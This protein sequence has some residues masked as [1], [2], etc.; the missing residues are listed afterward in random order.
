MRN[1]SR[2]VITLICLAGGTAAL[3]QAPAN[4]QQLEF[5]EKRIRPLLAQNCY[6]CHSH[7]GEKLKA[8][9]FLDSR[10]GV[11]KGGD[12]GPAIVPGNPRRSLVIT[13]VKWTD[14]DLQMPPKTKLG[15]DAIADL[16]EWVKMGAP[17]P[18]EAA[19]KAGAESKY[20]DPAKQYER[21]RQ[22]HW[23]WQRISDPQAPVVKNDKWPRDD[24]DRF[25]L[26]PLE[27]KNLTPSA[28]AD[29]L[30]LLRRATFDLTGLPPTPEEID[31]FLRDS[32]PGAFEKVVDRLLAS[33]RFGERW[34][35]HWLDVARYAE[36]S[37]MTRNLIYFYAWRYR[38]YV[39]DSF[40]ADKPY[41]RFITEQIAGDLLPAKSQ[42]EKDQL[43]VATGFLAIGPRDYNER[44]PRQFQMNC[45]DEQIDTMG[46]SILATTIACARCHDHKFDPIP[47]AEYYALAG[48]LTSS[49]EYTGV[50]RRNNPGN[51]F[52]RYDD[53][54]LVK[55]AG[56]KPESNAKEQ[57]D[58][59]ELREKGR[60]FMARMAMS[61]RSGQGFTQP[62]TP[63]RP[64]AMGV[65][66]GPRVGD[67]RL[68]VRGEVGEPAAIVKRGFLSIP[69]IKSAPA[70]ISLGTSGRVELAR[71]LTARDNPL[72][73]RVMANRVWRHLFGAGLVRSVD[74]FG[75]TGERPSN[76]ELLDHLATQFMNDGWSVKK[77]IRRIMLTSAY[78]QSAAFD[79]AKYK[80]DPENRLLW[81]MNQRRLE[82]E[83]IRDA[84]LASSG[85]LAT[86]RPFGSVVLDFPPMEVRPGNGRIDVSEILANTTARS[87]YLPIFRNVIPEVLD[88][89]D[90]ADP[91][92]VTGQRDVTTVAPQAL[93]MLNNTFVTAQAKE[94]ATRVAKTAA[95]NDSAR[96]D[97]AYKLAL[98]RSPTTGERSR[99]IAYIDNYLRD[100]NA[101]KSRDPD[102]NQ[103]E[104]WT[105][106]CQ[107]LF[108]SAEF[109]YLN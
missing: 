87:V 60:R 72:T 99:A 29:K 13:A 46:R 49:R 9:L 33:P 27:E 12:T 41:D 77:L 82:A 79:R 42:K 93:F 23:S 15:D 28:P 75:T 80:I 63:P 24:I 108:A 47:T 58:E 85:R 8:N 51:P 43:V 36:S 3:A 70:T 69:A 20:A 25:V 34:G 98:G 73:A 78:Q 64:L 83:S 2:V 32:S 84:M 92:V 67:T 109:R 86:Q 57:A 106:L 21:L 18:N 48:I 81:R 11:L 10:D 68:L 19:P 6:K 66:D 65:T 94:F 38:D 39:I 90:F 1:C 100:P 50:T 7:A 53:D 102:K 30:S 45:V 107:A 4:P 74:N 62:Q 40:N 91:N 88:A 105:S 104:A 61:A 56:Y 103:L 95:K 16:E 17:W 37:G 89:F 71:W 35:R 55:L 26:A 5:F 44:N 96:I 22:E 101:G 59:Q 31:A 14:P 54:E 76:P 97:L 52:D